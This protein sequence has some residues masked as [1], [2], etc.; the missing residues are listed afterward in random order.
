MHPSVLNMLFGEHTDAVL[1]YGLPIDA[2]CRLDTPKRHALVASVTTARS[3][4]QKLEVSKVCGLLAK[5]GDGVSLRSLLHPGLADIP[6]SV[7]NRI[8]DHSLWSAKDYRQILKLSKCPEARAI[9]RHSRQINRS[10][11]A[12]LN[13]LSAPWRKRGIF[14]VLE[15]LQQARALMCLGEA[16]RFVADADRE[17]AFVAAIDSSGSF[18]GIE[19]RFWRILYKNQTSPEAPLNSTQSF[20]RINSE[21]Q[22]RKLAKAGHCFGDLSMIEA[23]FTSDS[24][25]YSWTGAKDAVVELIRDAG[26][27]GWYIGETCRPK[28][29]SLTRLQFKALEEDLSQLRAPVSSNQWTRKI[30]SAFRALRG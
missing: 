5:K 28:T 23:V 26:P 16:V 22:C 12:I 24:L 4:R 21:E 11:I 7:F 15:T 10:D 25:F 2:F 13:E 19:E 14:E 17:R 18:S 30:Q 20:E 6:Y 1:G 3:Q 27:F 8:S 29:K 9:L